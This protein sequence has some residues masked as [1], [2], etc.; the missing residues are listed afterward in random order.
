MDALKKLVARC[1]EMDITEQINW[2]FDA[3]M[4]YQ[5]QKEL[6]AL[7]AVAEAA[8]KANKELRRKLKDGETIYNILYSAQEMLTDALKGAE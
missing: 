3:S 2:L 7:E 1:N 4:P 6:A 8:R 5:A